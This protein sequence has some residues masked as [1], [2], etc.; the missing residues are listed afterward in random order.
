M[1][2]MGRFREHSTLSTPNLESE[3]GITA[4]ICQRVE[5]KKHPS[6]SGMR[7]GGEHSCCEQVAV[8]Q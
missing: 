5:Q 8:Q 4:A 3:E 6:P 7:T 2:W 1:C